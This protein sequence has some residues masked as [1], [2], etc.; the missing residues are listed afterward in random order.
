MGKV[1]ITIRCNRCDEIETVVTEAWSTLKTTCGCE[2]PYRVLD[3]KL[4]PET[5]AAAGA[6]RSDGTKKD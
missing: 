1:E 6:G 5:D 4:L 2:G 3:R